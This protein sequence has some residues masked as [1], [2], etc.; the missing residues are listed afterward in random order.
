MRPSAGRSFP[1]PTTM[2]GTFRYQPASH[3]SDVVNGFALSGNI[4]GPSYH[5]QGGN[6]WSNYGN[7]LNP[8][9]KLPYVNTFS[10]SDYVGSDVLPPGTDTVHRSIL[11]GGDYHPL[12]RA[13]T[14]LIPVAFI[15]SGLPPFSAWEASIG[16]SLWYGSS[17][18]IVQLFAPAGAQS[19]SVLVPA[20]YVLTSITGPNSPTLSSIDV[21]G[22]SLYHLTFA[23]VI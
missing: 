1:P 5:W 4:L 21:T 12:L 22:P 3:V 6:Y 10:Y 8:I 23:P 13:P 9:G 2:P 17:S 16:P 15:E 7:L 14:G 20:G 11:V 18:L 19:F